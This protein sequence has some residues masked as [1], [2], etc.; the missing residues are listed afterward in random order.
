MGEEARRNE[1]RLDN[2]ARLLAADDAAFLIRAISPA[3]LDGV[4]VISVD[5]RGSILVNNGVSARGPGGASDMI[6]PNMGCRN[7]G[8]VCKLSTRCR[9]SDAEIRCSSSPASVSSC[10]SV[11]ADGIAVGAFRF[12]IPG[13]LSEDCTSQQLRLSTDTDKL[14]SH[15]SGVKF[16]VMSRHTSTAITVF[17]TVK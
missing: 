7:D 12:G 17:V 14:V 2:G 1:D 6:D 8:P 9:I 11:N 5:A 13:L 16:N 3:S 15:C 4:I 10:H